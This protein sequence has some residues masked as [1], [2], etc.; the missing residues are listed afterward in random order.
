MKSRSV[1]AIA[2]ASAL[3]A[4]PAHAFRQPAYLAERPLETAGGERARLSRDATWTVPAKQ[5]RAWG[6]FLAR[7][8]SWRALWDGA[9][10][11]PT[12][13]YGEGI[14]APAAIADGAKAE[15]IAREVLA[16]HLALLAPGASL[17]DFTLAL[18]ALNPADP[19]RRVV[20]LAQTFRGRA[21]V[22][23]AV[24]FLFAH[25]RLI[26]IGSTASPAVAAVEPAQ[27]VDD[28]R[29][30]QAATEWIR[31]VYAGDPRV[32][33]HGPA[34]VLPI[35]RDDGAL[36]HRLV[37]SVTVDLATPRAQWT[38]YLDAGT[39]APV[40]RVQRLMFADGTLRYRVPVRHPDPGGVFE[41][42][43]AAFAT[44]TVDATLATSSAAGG[45]T[46]AGALAAS[47]TPTVTGTYAA[48]TNSAGPAATTTFNVDPAGEAVWDL[49][50][51]GAAAAQL[52]AFVRSTI[53][54]RF[55]LATLNPGLPWLSQAMPVFVN[56][57]GACN[58]YS[59][60]DDIHFFPAY[61]SGGTRCANTALLADVVYHEIG[62]SLHIQSLMSGQFDSGLSEGIS[63]YLAATLIGDPAMGRGFFQTDEPLRHIDPD[64]FE[65]RWPDAL[66]PDP[67]ITG[68]VI[69]GALW[70]LRTALIADL[71]EA[72]GIAR[73]DD[74]FYGVIQRSSDTPSSFVEALATD[75][76]DGNLA[77]GTPNECAI[78]RAFGAHGLTDIEGGG[79]IRAPRLD[80]LTLTLDQVIGADVC[81][82]PAILGGTVTWRL[83]D[84][85]ET[86]GEVVLEP[87]AGGF[88]ATLP[89]ID[90][91]EVVQYQLLVELDGGNLSPVPYNSVDP[92][93]ELYVGPVIQIYCTD[94]EADPFQEGWRFTRGFEWDDARAGVRGLDPPGAYSGENIIGT[95][96][97]ADGAYDRNETAQATSPKFDVSRFSSVRLQYRRWLGVEDGNYDQAAVLADGVALWSNPARNDG[98]GA[99]LDHE[100]RFHDVDL[101]PMIG[102]GDVTVGFRLISNES[103]QAGGWNVDD[104]CLVTP[105]V[106]V[107]GDGF[108]S[109]DEE[110]DDG[111]DVDG[112][113]CAA[114]CIAELPPEEPTEDGGCCTTGG[115]D[116][117][118]AL[119]LA[120]ATVA[121]GVR[122]RR[123]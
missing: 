4:A 81:G 102:N 10:T 120:L 94:F 59:N 50:A 80:G 19:T 73:A 9:T 21:V 91:D 68:L 113:G 49:N 61:A 12:R 71:G 79:V 7:H 3:V 118:G 117:T 67:H 47:V 45:F 108:A 90:D 38:V 22:D 100:W 56:E 8:G 43:P 99:L 70:D 104:L 83:R 78:R 107:C 62:H 18:N 41:D 66:H 106:P 51:D 105:G 16:E 14:A 35:V 15:T 32:L 42:L 89:P 36:E 95:G 25:D 76:D 63:D 11:V 29:A 53:A 116:G 115:G 93:Y 54:K 119:L 6:E 103:G 39:G 122:R 33:G 55:A 26:V 86:T 5:A 72:A 111:N 20:V 34:V 17:G 82:P 75:D 57:E 44:L 23:A 101:T 60:G 123:R 74:I 52:S 58:A 112:D 30:A 65:Y 46:W 85:P 28:D 84:T 24:S 97:G 48:V 114:G 96:I 87:T 92:W 64:G 69:A 2:L 109:A 1:A 98:Q 77:N 37:V 13:I 27:L 110:C 121:V 31:R 88:T 40:A